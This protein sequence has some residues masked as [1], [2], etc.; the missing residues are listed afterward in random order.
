MDKK[1][2]VMNIQYQII[3]C[4]KDLK[5]LFIINVPNA[6]MSNISMFVLFALVYCHLVDLMDFN[7]CF[8]IS[9]LIESQT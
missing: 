4:H 5:L 2:L 3:M 9:K 6:I 1:N 7:S 8:N